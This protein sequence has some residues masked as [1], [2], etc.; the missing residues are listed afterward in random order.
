ML[1]KYLIQLN[2]VFEYI[3]NR[4]SVGADISIICDEVI[5]RFSPEIIF[6]ENSSEG[7]RDIVMVLC[8]YAYFLYHN[9]T[10]DTP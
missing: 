2:N 1:K 6:S 9:T 5:D 4:T 3:R 10:Y 7:L 8:K